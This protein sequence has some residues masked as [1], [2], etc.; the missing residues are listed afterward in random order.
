M[1][2]HEYINGFQLHCYSL[3]RHT[4]RFMPIRL[5]YANKTNRRR[6]I[7][8]TRVS[9]KSENDEINSS[10]KCVRVSQSPENVW[11]VY[12]NGETLKISFESRRDLT[13]RKTEEHSREERAERRREEGVLFTLLSGKV[14][15]QKERE[16]NRMRIPLYLER[17]EGRASLLTMTPPTH[18][19]TR[20][21]CVGASSVGKWI[22]VTLGGKQY[23]IMG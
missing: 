14:L 3:G 15:T 17:G 4:R 20:R 6:R 5:E 11:N 1:T 9:W 7:L 8:E 16:T 23:L 21:R 18:A 10:E 22:Y 12:F 19:W 2:I 13:G